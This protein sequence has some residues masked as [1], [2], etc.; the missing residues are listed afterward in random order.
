[1]EFGLLGYYGSYNHNNMHIIDFNDK[2][3]LLEYDVLIID[4][5][6][7]FS[8]YES[9]EVFNGK[10][11]LNQR[12]S[13]KIIEDIQKRK[14]EINEF[15]ESGKTIIVVSTNEEY[16]YA[17]TGKYDVSGTGKNA[18]KTNI[19][20]DVH[21]KSI[22]PFK[23]KDLDLTGNKIKF[24]NKM[25]EDHLKKYSKYIEYNTIYSDI[26]K[27]NQI[28]NVENSK[29]TVCYYER[30]GNGLIVF[31]PNI[32]FD[33][34]EKKLFSK[35]ERDYFLELA[36]IK[37]YI[38]SDKEELPEYA[39]EYYLPSERETINSIE[40]AN[41]KINKLKESI[42]KDKLKLDAIQ[43][44][45]VL[46]TGTGKSLEKNVVE[47]LKVIG[48]NIIKY[49]DDSVD[50][51]IVFEYKD[52]LFISEVKGVS[53][54]ATEKHTAQTVKW[55]TEYYIEND[56]M[57]KGVLI[58]NAFNNKKLED[59]Q[60]YF[61][62]QMLKYAEHQEIC[63]ITT[64]QIYNIMCFIEQNPLEVDSIIQEIFDCNGIFTN[65]NEWNNY[66]SK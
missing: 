38:I 66:I 48:F 51:D 60:E 52:K 3:T 30:V 45:K 59:R 26:E 54:S 32:V 34:S 23:V 40:L 25:I 13:N 22:I 63:L 64:I 36:N 14:E 11:L 24:C 50:E 61:P 35:I 6:R 28:M 15:L 39:S 5:K 33:T 9:Y 10:R 2:R 55:K 43:Q 8:C 46:F 62:N 7:L 37:K 56:I 58:V 1:M 49:N 42:K 29:K 57:P 53:G 18:R 19:V 65:F 31:A 21:P 41:D 12:D 27:T 16:V 4:L 47:M 17:Y 44:K 20:T